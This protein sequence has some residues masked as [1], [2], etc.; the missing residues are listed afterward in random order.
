MPNAI[1]LRP[2]I[3]ERA[4][5]KCTGD[6]AYLQVQVQDAAIKGEDGTVLVLVIDE[7]GHR[8]WIEV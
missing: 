2:D 4:V 3:K 1:P 5:K 8:F 7:K 6:L